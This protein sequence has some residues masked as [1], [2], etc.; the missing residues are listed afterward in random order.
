DRH[1][2][3]AP[4]HP[5]RHCTPEQTG[6]DEPHVSHANPPSTIQTG[7]RPG[8]GSV[9]RAGTLHSAPLPRRRAVRACAHYAARSES[10]I[11]CEP[12][13]GLTWFDAFPAACSWR[14]PASFS[15]TALLLLL[16][17]STM[18]VERRF[19]QSRRAP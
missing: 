8:P 2:V 15:A 19:W 12:H 4:K 5:F 7:L 3:A 10:K 17:G 9:A 1:R 6:S 18:A 13:N 11:R 14:P 16:A